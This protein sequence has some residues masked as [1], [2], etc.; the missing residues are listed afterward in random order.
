M[1]ESHCLTTFCSPAETYYKGDRPPSYRSMSSTIMDPRN[2]IVVATSITLKPGSVEIPPIG[3]PIAGATAY[4]LDE[5]GKP[6]PDGNP[7][8]IYIGGRGVG[9]GYRNLPELTERSFLPD[10]FAGVPMQECTAQVTAVSGGRTGRSNF[11]GASIDRLRFADNELSW[12]R[13]AAFSVATRAL[14]LLPRLPVP[15]RPE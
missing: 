13:S 8:E 4:L 5:G 11:A 7:G 6:V 14:I 3:R 1:A 10:P 2:A 9:R 15:Q 12:M